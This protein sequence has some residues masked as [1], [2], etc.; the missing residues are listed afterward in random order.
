VLARRSAVRTPAAEHFGEYRM[1]SPT[2][3]RLSTL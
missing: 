3:K 1:N 2:A